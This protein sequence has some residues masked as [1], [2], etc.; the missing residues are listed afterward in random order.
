M[1]LQDGAGAAFLSTTYDMSVHYNENLLV[2]VSRDI[3]GYYRFYVNGKEV[4]DVQETKI[5]GTNAQLLHC[6]KLSVAPNDHINATQ[7]M[8]LIGK[9]YSLSTDEWSQLYL[10]PFAPFRQTDRML[11]E[12]IYPLRYEGWSR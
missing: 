6:G 1:R 7:Y 11:T 3:G 4:Y 5:P 12:P 9:G 2:G 8:A 10:D